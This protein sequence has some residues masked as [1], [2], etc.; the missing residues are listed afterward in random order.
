MV[1]DLPDIPKL[2][3]ISSNDEEPNDKLEGDLEEEPEEEE[4]EEGD[5]KEDPVDDPEMGSHIQSS[6]LRIED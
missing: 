5:P 6:A 4:P 3:E 1:V 2:M